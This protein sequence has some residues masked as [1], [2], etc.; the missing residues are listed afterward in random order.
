M[1]ISNVSGSST[2][3]YQMEIQLQNEKEKKAAEQA[4]SQQVQVTALTEL[5]GTAAPNVQ[6]QS[7][8]IKQS[9]DTIEISAEGRAYQQKSQAAAITD[10]TESN[11]SSSQN[12]TGLTEDEIQ[13][14]V[15]KGTITQ[16]QANAE[17]LKRASKEDQ[18]EMSADM[19]DPELYMDDES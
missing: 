3:D 13:K 11:D 9:Q 12:L 16:A 10:S 18:K 2:Q 6:T 19:K 4:A 1:S 17:L 8:S 14:L 15:D 5:G 7:S